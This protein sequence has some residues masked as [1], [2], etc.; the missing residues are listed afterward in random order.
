MFW[1]VLVLVTGFMLFALA[2]V[3]DGNFVPILIIVRFARLMIWLEIVRWVNCPSSDSGESEDYFEWTNTLNQRNQSIE[4][5]RFFVYLIGYMGFFPYDLAAYKSISLIVL[6]ISVMAGISYLINIL[7]LL[8][9]KQKTPA[10]IKH[11]LWSVPMR[12]TVYITLVDC[13]IIVFLSPL[14]ALVAYKQ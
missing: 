14:I 5:L 13:L 2:S 3:S 10:L 8:S 7:K 9:Y 12:E 4:M 6:R 11:H 1:P